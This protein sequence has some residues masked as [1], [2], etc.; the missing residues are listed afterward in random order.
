MTVDEPVYT[1]AGDDSEGLFAG[2]IEYRN[3][4]IL[5]TGLFVTVVVTLGIWNNRSVGALRCFTVG[6]LPF[7]STLVWVFGFRQ[8]KPKAH[9]RDLLQTA[10]SGKSWRPSE[11]QRSH[12]LQDSNIKPRFAGAAPNGWFCNDLVVWNCISK[13]GIH[14]EGL[15]L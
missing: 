8:N 5:L 4:Y 6:S 15:Y 12:P 13:G 9:D 14:F 1:Y 11:N 2:F 10:V 3:L 7:V